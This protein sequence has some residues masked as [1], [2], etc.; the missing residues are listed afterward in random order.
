M[1]LE[2]Y[3]NDVLLSLYEVVKDTLNYDEE[4]LLIGR[5]NA[6]QDTFTKNYKV[7][8]TLASN[9]V[10]QPLKKYDDV[11]EIEYWQ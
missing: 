7:L 11:D 5:E 10:S 1:I 2:E 9:P 4:L 3:E 6:T 8:D